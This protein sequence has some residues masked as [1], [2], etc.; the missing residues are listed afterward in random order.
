MTNLHGFTN[1]IISFLVLFLGALIAPFI[2]E[3]TKALVSKLQGDK[4]IIENKQLSLNP[5]KYF[6]PIGFMLLIFF[7]YG[8]GKPVQ[9]NSRYYK[10]QKKS[11]I[12]TFTAPIIAN[13]L[14]ALI[15]YNL[16]FLWNGFN[17]IGYFNVSLAVF[18]IIPI[19]PLCG[20]QILKYLLKPNSALK[21]MQYESF[22]RMLVIILITLPLT[23]SILNMFVDLL[24]ILIQFFVIIK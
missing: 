8:W 20:E 10:N 4:S 2:H 1:L 7:G 23:R 3:F 16:G 18:N 24:S 19:Y 14:F 11:T 21:Y 22:I 12:I 6:E 17:T 5:F 13:L 15:F 9:V